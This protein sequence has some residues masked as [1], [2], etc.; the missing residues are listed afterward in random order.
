MTKATS[1]AMASRGGGPLYAQIAAAIASGIA[2]GR[3]EPGYR[4][5]PEPE[6][7]ASLGV[8]RLTLRQALTVLEGRGLIDR[9]V[10]RHGGT[11]VRKWTVDR[12]LTTFAGFSEQLRRQGRVAGAEVLSAREIGA[13]APVAA[14]LDIAE[15]SPVYEV[16]RLRL[17]SG[18]PVLL[19]CSSFPAEAFPGLLDEPLDQSLYG[20][21][22]ERYGRRPTHAREVLEPVPADRRAARLL[23]VSA[24]TPVL[25]VERTAF[26]SD[27]TPVEYAKD[28]FLGDRTRVVVWSF[29]V[30]AH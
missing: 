11:F 28:L 15:E 13:S 26:D 18:T 23:R 8:S 29:D 25:L 5:P 14:G 27:G 7:A 22:G 4:F 1:A 30:P 3:Y 10:G 2:D 12:D 21:L 16:Q 19:E 24:G 17:A 20:L 6:L 9:V